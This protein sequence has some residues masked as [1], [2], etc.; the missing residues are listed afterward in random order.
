MLGIVYEQTVG[1]ETISDKDKETLLQVDY[2]QAGL[3]LSWQPGGL[4]YLVNI[5]YDR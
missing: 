2:D 4:A 5:S 1:R 3:P